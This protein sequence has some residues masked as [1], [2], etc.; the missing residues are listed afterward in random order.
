M[1][2][3]YLQEY[4]QDESPLSHHKV[5]N[6]IQEASYLKNLKVMIHSRLT[7]FRYMIRFSLNEPPFQES[8]L[9]HFKGNDSGSCLEATKGTS[10]NT[11]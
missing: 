1:K 9:H 2:V 5:M 11:T 10:F 7:S 6:N 4:F 8:T 3:K